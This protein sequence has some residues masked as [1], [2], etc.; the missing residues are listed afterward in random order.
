MIVSKH[1]FM[2]KFQYYGSI[3]AKS[4]FIAVVILLLF[5]AL[6]AVIYCA[7][8]VLNV[9]SGNYNSPIFNGYVIVSRSMVPTINKNDAIVIKRED[10]DKYAIGDIISFYSTEYDSK[11]MI[12]THR[13]VKKNFLGS[14]SYN[15][16]TKGDNN[17]NPDRKSVNS[18]NVYGRVFLIIPR[19]GYAQSFLSKPINFALCILLPSLLI[20]IY[21]ILRIFQSMERNKEIF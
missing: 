14:S 17:L 20:I 15:Y 18:S 3:I 2:A 7:D 6:L 5:V 19:L 13:I 16:T 10:T 4:F 8:L 1:N 9:K 21:D 11:G 12:V